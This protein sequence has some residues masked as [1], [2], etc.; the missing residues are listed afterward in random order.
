MAQEASIRPNPH[1]SCHLSDT[2]LAGLSLISDEFLITSITSKAVNEGAA[3]LTSATM[4]EAIGVAIL[5]PSF[6]S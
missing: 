2:V 1:F 5:V 3:S 4:P 6:S